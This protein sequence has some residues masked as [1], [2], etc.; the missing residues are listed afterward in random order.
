M[1]LKLIL[2]FS[3]LALLCQGCNLVKSAVGNVAFEICL[4]AEDCQEKIRD[5]RWANEAW[6]AT[7]AA[8]PEHVYSADFAEGFKDGFVD[9]VHS[10][11]TA[12]PPP[13]P[14][15][16]Y[17]KVGYQTSEGHQAIEDWFAGFR[18]GVQVAN[19]AGYRNLVT[20]PTALQGPVNFP[21]PLYPLVNGPEQGVMP[22]SKLPVPKTDQEGTTEELPKPSQVVPTSKPVQAAGDIKQTTTPANCL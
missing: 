5:R 17:W 16:R 13:L 22:P 1:R 19:E 6:L 10:G 14:P 15:T 4:C 20:L 18:Q 12:G 8:D 21:P 11:G 2:W 9:F 3:G 7:Q